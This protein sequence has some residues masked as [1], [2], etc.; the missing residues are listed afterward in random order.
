VTEDKEIEISVE[1]E[2]RDVLA[3]YQIV[4]ELE[5]EASCGTEVV[6]VCEATHHDDDTVLAAMTLHLP[7]SS[8]EDHRALTKEDNQSQ[9]ISLAIV[10]MAKLLL[11][12]EQIRPE[13]NPFGSVQCAEA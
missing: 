7:V 12:Q 5:E 4:V 13:F 11:I 9:Y 3:R 10:A 8:S 1:E 6:L 2:I